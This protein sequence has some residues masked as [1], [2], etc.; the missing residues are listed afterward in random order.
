M[1]DLSSN[2]ADEQSE[3]FLLLQV[4]RPPNISKTESIEQPSF[5][6]D[7]QTRLPGNMLIGHANAWLIRLDSKNL[8][9]TYRQ[10]FE[11]LHRH[12]L[13]E[14]RFS[15]NSII[16]LIGTLDTA[17]KNLDSIQLLSNDDWVQQ[18]K[19]KVED[20]LNRRWSSYG[21]EQKFEIMK[22]IAKHIITVNDLVVDERAETILKECSTSTLIACTGTSNK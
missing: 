11:I 20:F 15:S 1:V 4:K 2:N 12:N 19:N 16:P 17:H 18:N 8:N 7:T 13:T 5:Q 9:H 10:L 22:L 14:G 21:F 6:Y 3:V